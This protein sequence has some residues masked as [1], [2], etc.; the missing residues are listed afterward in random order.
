[1]EN[2]VRFDGRVAIVTGAGSGMGRAYSNLLASR[3][4]AVVVNDLP[5]GGSGTGKSSSAAAVVE[6]I[7]AAG[8]N[9]VAIGGDVTSEPAMNALIGRTIDQFGRI[10][11]LISNAGTGSYVPFHQMTLE[12]FDRMIRVHLHGSFLSIRAAWPHMMERR[13]GRILTTGSSAIFGI[14]KQA[15]YGAAKGGVAALT[16]SLSVEG[17]EHGIL[18]NTIFPLADTPL[19]RRLAAEAN[20]GPDSAAFTTKLAELGALG[21]GPELVAAAA[22]WLVHEDSKVTGQMIQTGMGVAHRVSHS[23]GRGYVNPSMTIEAIRDHLGEVYESDPAG[24]FADL[25]SVLQ[26]FIKARGL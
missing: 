20:M 8:G 6:E 13:Y 21:A 5:D 17:E 24:E 11:I 18:V 12:Q 9:A 1:L 23:Y 22:V 2:T 3:G 26:F 25:N 4:A 7:A 14:G 15:H 19:A 16:K 10:D